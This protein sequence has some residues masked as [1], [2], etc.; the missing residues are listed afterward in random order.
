MILR[1]APLSKGQCGPLAQ[2]EAILSPSLETH[3]GHSA[4]NRA[5]ASGG[6][7]RAASCAPRASRDRGNQTC[8]LDPQQ[9]GVRLAAYPRPPPTSV[10]RR[11]PPHPPTDQVSLSLLSQKLPGPHGSWEGRC[12][13][14]L[15]EAEFVTRVEVVCT[16]GSGHSR[17]E[18]RPCA[19]GRRHPADISVDPSFPSPVGARIGQHQDHLV[20]GTHP[21]YL[22]SHLVA[23]PNRRQTQ[24][25][26][27]SEKVPEPLLLTRTLALGSPSSPQ[28]PSPA[29]QASKNRWLLYSLQVRSQR[30]DL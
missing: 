17:S 15:R 4:A 5:E 18:G 19:S 26:G 14:Q 24:A 21:L 23:D 13:R 22:C 7:P 10:P 6:R 25:L 28:T 11:G 9:A 30:R 12:P 8:L 3:P 2:N 16:G 27:Q 29:C 20:P 1:P